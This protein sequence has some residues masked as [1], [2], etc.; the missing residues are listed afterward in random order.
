[1]ESAAPGKKSSRKMRRFPRHQLDVRMLVHVFR[2]GVSSTIWGRS[3]MMGQEGIGGTLTGD[4]ELGEVVGLEFGLP[5]CPQ[6]VKLRAIV[7]YKNGFQY[8]FEFLAVDALQR[9][10][11]QRACE[12]LPLTVE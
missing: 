12:I 10:A 7:R 11:L 3:T 4:L 5:L 6:A 9:Q 1:M 2:D 8:G